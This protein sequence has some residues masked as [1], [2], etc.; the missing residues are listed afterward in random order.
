V[1]FYLFLL[2]ALVD[3]NR[4]MESVD[5]QQQHG[6]QSAGPTTITTTPSL[7]PGGDSEYSEVLLDEPDHPEQLTNEEEDEPRIVIHEKNKQQSQSSSS[8]SAKDQNNHVEVDGTGQPQPVSV[9]TDP[10]PPQSVD[11]PKSGSGSGS[12]ASSPIPVSPHKTRFSV[13]VRHGKECTGDIITY[14]VSSKRLFDDKGIGNEGKTYTVLRVYEDF[15]FLDQCLIMAAFAGQYFCI[16]LFMAAAV[17]LIFFAV[18]SYIIFFC[19][20]PKP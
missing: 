4:V 11:D 20:S 17:N 14:S 19:E 13:T 7:V 18:L 3:K 16:L 1:H 5:Q 2:K 6:S 10:V 9:K 8:S 12:S 15:E